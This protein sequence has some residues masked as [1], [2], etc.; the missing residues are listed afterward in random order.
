MTKKITTKLWDGV[1]TTLLPEE[2]LKSKNYTYTVKELINDGASI[3]YKAVRSDRKKI[4]LKQ[5]KEPTEANSKDWDEFIKFQYSVLKTLIKL[6][7]SIVEKNYEYFEFNGVHFHAK[8]YE[9]GSDLNHVIFNDKRDFKTR[10]H[11]AKVTL[12][13][14]RLVHKTGIVHSDLKPQQFYLV[15]NEKLDIGFSVKL[16]DFD[17]CII[18]D[19][20]MKRPAGTD[21]W[22]SPEHIL[23]KDISF[24]SD[25]FTMGQIL[26][27]LLTNGRQP[28]KDSIINDTYDKDIFTRE[29]YVCLHT[30]F[31]GQLPLPLSEI[32]DAMLSPDPKERPSIAEVHDIFLGKQLASATK[33]ELTLIS[34][35]KS[36]KIKASQVITR[37]V[38]MNH[39]GNHDEIYKN[40]FEVIQDNNSDWF[41]RGLE[42][43]RKAKD[44][45]GKTH[46]FHRTL[47]EGN[48]ITNK[49]VKI[50]R[51][52]VIEIGSTRFI[53]KVG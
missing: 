19:L 16:I 43:P 38:V 25:V 35:G 5:F 2:K 24:H 40:Q 10:I 14:L 1:S 50:Q 34:N 30:L 23:N 26:Y 7:T 31:R 9:F 17:H 8:N 15:D 3:V 32:I 53:L 46:V 12:G 29:G 51:S 48:D 21:G 52:G 49:F 44:S 11:I 18:P 36:L 22:K 41:I 45:D 6:P 13:I 42:I 27:T 28:Y 33:G 20:N 47:F 4:F 39:F 37:E